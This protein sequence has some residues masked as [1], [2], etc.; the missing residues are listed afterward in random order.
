MAV[1]RP[2]WW[3]YPQRCSNGHEWGPG[4]IV[5]SWSPCD[6]PPAVAASGGGAAG[7]LAVYCAASPGCRSVVPAALRARE[8]VT[9]QPDIAM[10]RRRVMRDAA[11][12]AP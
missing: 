5:V 9:A 3:C 11:D 7:H 4:L 2:D 1:V 10:L 6:C 12:Y 8:P